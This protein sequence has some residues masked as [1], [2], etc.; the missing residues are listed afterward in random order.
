MRAVSVLLLIML[1]F[2]AAKVV[3]KG[4][5]LTAP[6]FLE[7][8]F[9][10]TSPELHAHWLTDEDKQ[11]AKEIFN[12]DYAGLRVRYWRSGDRTAWIFDEIG[13]TQ[14]ITI[15][16]L[17]AEHQIKNISILEFRE[18]RGGEVRH[19]FFTSQFVGLSLRRQDSERDN[20]VEVDSTAELDGTID[21]ITG[22]TLSVRAVTRVAKFAL[23]LST[24]V[25]RQGQAVLHDSTTSSR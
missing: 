13:K 25:E 9:G 18:S 6:A 19:P 8:S 21:G 24:Q 23:Y 1:P 15:G 17:I 7:Q 4:V 2:V 14:P 20:K 5:Y 16:V 22:A 3:A 10:T 12:R 11:R